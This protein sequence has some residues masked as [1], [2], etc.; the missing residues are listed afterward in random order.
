MA[1]SGVYWMRFASA[2]S[3]VVAAA[4]LALSAAA[5]Q[6]W[7]HH[8]NAMFDQQREQTITGVVKQFQ[9][10]NPHCYI[11][12]MAKDAKGKQV[13]WSIEMGA[14]MYLYARGWRPGS[15]K[16]GTPI[17]V[18]FNPLRSGDPGGVVLEV[19]RVDG[20]PVGKVK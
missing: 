12:V 20:Q 11:Q 6:A 14:P 4:L 16:A 19:T 2:R 18:R 9:W 15:L 10:T 3:W 1:R 17:T 13:E 5:P 8:S 7:A